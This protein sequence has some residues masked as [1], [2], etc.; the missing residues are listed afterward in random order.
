MGAQ[1]IIVC[2]CLLS[3]GCVHKDEEAPPA[4]PVDPRTAYAGEYAGVLHKHGWVAGA[5]TVLVD[6]TYNDTVRVGLCDAYPLQVCLEG[7]AVYA[8][9]EVDGGGGFHSAYYSPG[10]GF[11]LTGRFALGA[12]PD[13]LVFTQFSYL[14]TQYS[15]N[16]SFRGIRIE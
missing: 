2:C 6:T 14:Y 13:S 7:N 11:N 1:R 16:T 5:D 8:H 12:G 10:S 9:A 15:M 3:A 4:P